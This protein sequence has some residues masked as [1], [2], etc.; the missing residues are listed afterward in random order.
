MLRRR[1]SRKPDR[2]SWCRHYDEWKRA[3]DESEA[4]MARNSKHTA[5][6]SPE[7]LLRLEELT[8]VYGEAAIRMWDEAPES[9]N[10]ASAHIKCG[11]PAS[12]RL[13]LGQ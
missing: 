9:E 7:D 13:P 6:W 5:D 11:Y 1:K 8:K 10:W 12:R 3:Y 2:P 4:L